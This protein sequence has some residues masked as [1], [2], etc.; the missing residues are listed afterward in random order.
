MYY[1]GAAAAFKRRHAS[2][3]YA[4]EYGRIHILNFT[5]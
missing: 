4:T 2:L 3:F 1:Y 5:I